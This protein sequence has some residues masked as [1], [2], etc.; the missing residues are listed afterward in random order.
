[1]GQ[2]EGTLR[3]LR[4]QRPK[5]GGPLG[6]THFQKSRANA[7]L[8]ANILDAD[9]AAGTPRSTSRHRTG[10]GR[11]PRLPRARRGG[12]GPHTLRTSA[13]A[14]GRRP[15]PQPVWQNVPPGALP[16]V[17]PQRV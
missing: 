12:P 5:T 17:G 14:P 11:R 9:A 6:L 10:R 4:E 13:A 1:M 3:P 7:R 16:V 8:R 15:S 2:G